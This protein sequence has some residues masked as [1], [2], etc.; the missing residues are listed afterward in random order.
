MAGFGRW[1]VKDADNR[2]FE[3]DEQQK[4]SSCGPTSV[5]IVKESVHAQKVSEEFMREVTALFK[6]DLDHND[7]HS[8]ATSVHNWTTR[9]SNAQDLIKALQA[10]PLPIAAAKRVDQNLAAAILGASRNHPALLFCKWGGPGA[11]WIVSMG[12]LRSSATRATV[13]DPTYGLG[14]VDTSVTLGG[15]IKYRNTGQ[16]K[17]LIST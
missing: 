15:F 2:W 12:K 8:V 1:K 6:H 10:Q 17:W 13:L 5:K 3:F 9:G 14:Y 16:I 7:V 4:N 11:H